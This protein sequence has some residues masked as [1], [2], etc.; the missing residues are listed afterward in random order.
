MATCS[1]NIETV[2][3]AVGAKRL[4]HDC[5]TDGQLAAAVD[6]WWHLVAAKLECRSSTRPASTGT[7]NSTGRLRW[8]GIATGCDAIRRAARSGRPPR[9]ERRCPVSKVTSSPSAFWSHKR[10]TEEAIRL[11]WPEV[12]NF[13]EDEMREIVNDIRTLL[14][15]AENPNFMAWCD[16]VPPQ[17][18]KR[19]RRRLDWALMHQVKGY[20]RI[21]GRKG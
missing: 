11:P 14:V 16:F 17:R 15:K 9:T 2:A 10:R 21:R 3:R 18:Y 19:D 4:A 20:A 13:D 5:V 1:D 6:I 12:L 7:A 8:T